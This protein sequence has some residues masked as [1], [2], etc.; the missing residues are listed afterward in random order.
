M[1]VR[2]LSTFLCPKGPL[3][4]RLE[5]PYSQ[6]LKKF[7]KKEQELEADHLVL[8][9]ED[10]ERQALLDKGQVLIEFPMPDDSEIQIS[11][12]I[13][14]ET[15]D[16]QGQLIKVMIKKELANMVD[17]KKHMEKK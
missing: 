13:S 2:Q 1:S 9:L 10:I 6:V 7:E 14:H 5:V 8:G 11:D 12:A 3:A 4:M 17:L 15:V 16:S